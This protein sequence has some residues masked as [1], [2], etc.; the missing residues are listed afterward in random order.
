MA[1][2]QRNT[3]RPLINDPV[4]TSDIEEGEGEDEYAFAPDRGG[5][6]RAMQA[7]R[8]AVRQIS[9][10]RESKGS[11]TIVKTKEV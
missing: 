3:R 2:E 4:P 7:Y 10:K 11:L 6:G 8:I 1:N 9:N 5:D